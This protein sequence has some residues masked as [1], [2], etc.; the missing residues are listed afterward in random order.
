VRMHSTNIREATISI[1]CSGWVQYEQRSAPSC[2][3]VNAVDVSSK[4]VLSW[5][6]ITGWVRLETPDE[7][8]VLLCWLPAERRA[9]TYVAT[10]WA[11]RGY[12]L[13]IG[14]LSGAVT[15]LDFNKMLASMHMVDIEST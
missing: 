13:A 15:I 12:S 3:D 2:L 4:A 8:E 14:A 5:D 6:N 1:T 7:G 10:S 9:F 11:I